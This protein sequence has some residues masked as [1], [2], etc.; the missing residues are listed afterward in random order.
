MAV[1][2]SYHKAFHLTAI[3]R[4]APLPS[5]PMRLIRRTWKTSTIFVDGSKDP[6][7]SFP[8]DDSDPI[9]SPIQIQIRVYSL[10]TADRKQRLLTNIQ[11]EP[12]TKN[13]VTALWKKD[14]VDD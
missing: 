11:A 1:T 6:I 10:R 12:A 5:S 8:M 3:S 2:D 4:S 14:S 7:Y 9:T 13:A